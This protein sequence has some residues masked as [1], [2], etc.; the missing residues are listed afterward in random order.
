MGCFSFN[1]VNSNL[2]AWSSS[3][4][5]DAVRLFLLKDGKVIEEMKGYYDSYGRVF[6]KNGDSFKWE[7]SWGDVCDLMFDN[8]ESNGIALVLE[9]YWDGK[10]PT[11]RSEQDPHQGW[12]DKNGR[13]ITIDEPYH[14]SYIQQEKRNEL[15]SDI[16]RAN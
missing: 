13:D 5:G 11:N 16:L 7:T 14:Y 8:D 6:D 2:P 3:F 10:I 1:C 9:A 12:G 4:E 15:I